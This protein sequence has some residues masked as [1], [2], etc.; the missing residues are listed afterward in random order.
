MLN[1]EDYEE[2]RCLLCME[3]GDA[4]KTD[5]RRLAR[6]LDEFYASDDMQGAERFLLGWLDESLQTN[7]A[8]LEFF[9]RNEL[10]GV[11]RKTGRK[12]ESLKSSVQPTAATE[13]TL[14]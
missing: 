13:P 3:D 8:N 1:K 14:L 12:D 4:E 9:A 6:K 11:Y 2:P 7:D 10:I 5:T